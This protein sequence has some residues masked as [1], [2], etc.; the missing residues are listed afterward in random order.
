MQNVVI[1]KNY[2]KLSGS[3][4]D[5]TGG[6]TLSLSIY[7]SQEEGEREIGT[8][9]IYANNGQHYAGAVT[10]VEKKVYKIATDTGEEVLLVEGDYGDTIMLQLYVDGQFL[11]EYRMVEHYE[12]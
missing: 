7:S 8:A 2:W 6:F 10:P 12:S 1:Y 5:N 4:S 11:D 9:D 3:Y